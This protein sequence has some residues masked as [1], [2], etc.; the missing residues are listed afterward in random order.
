MLRTGHRVMAIGPSR[1]AL[2]IFTL[3]ILVYLAACVLAAVLLR[4]SLAGFWGILILSFILTP[5]VVLLASLLLR[6]EPAWLPAR[7]RK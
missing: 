6:P 4:R 3:P 5:L 7:F 2:L 1:S